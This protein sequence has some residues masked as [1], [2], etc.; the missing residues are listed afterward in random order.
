METELEIQIGLS[1][2]KLAVIL[3]SVGLAVQSLTERELFQKA[4]ELEVFQTA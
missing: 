2:E 3:M 1:P 4:V